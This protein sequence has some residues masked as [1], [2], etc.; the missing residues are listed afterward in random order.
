VRG[1]T[2]REGERENSDLICRMV[3]FQYNE[4]RIEIGNNKIVEGP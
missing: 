1:F 2:E 3:F 4:I